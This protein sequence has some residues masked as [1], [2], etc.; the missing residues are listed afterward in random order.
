VAILNDTRQTQPYQVDW[1]AVA[2]GKQ[3]GSG[4]ARGTIEVGSTK[5]E[6]LNFALPATAVGAGEVVANVKIG[7]NT[8]TDR[9]AFVSSHPCASER[10]NRGL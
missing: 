8:H 4:Q 7:A 9:F 6:A 10:R 2:G 3:L 1:R 5:F